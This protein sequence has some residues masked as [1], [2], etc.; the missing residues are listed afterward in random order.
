[1]P[2]KKT[3]S[4]EELT[5]STI[6]KEFQAA[7]D[8]H[9]AIVGGAY[10]DALLVTLLQSVFISE[11]DD[12]ELLLSEHGPLGS[13]GSR[14][15]LAYCLG[16]IRKHQRD[17]LACVAKIRNKF[18]HDHTS[19]SFDD[20]PICDLCRNLQQAQFLDTLRSVASRNKVKMSSLTISLSEGGDHPIDVEGYIK[21]LTETPRL[22]FTTTVITLAGSLLRRIDL[23]SRKDEKN[24]FSKN[25]DQHLPI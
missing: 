16:L 3:K 9:V 17:D 13:N 18:A 21:S 7:S 10:L 4:A 8:R 20:A 11:Q 15:K 14:C 5:I 22:K 1:M 12:A 6:D 25:P 19:L 24:W 2:K 23:V